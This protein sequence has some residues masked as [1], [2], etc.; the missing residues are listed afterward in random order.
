MRKYVSI[1][2]SRGESDEAPPPAPT[3]KTPAKPAANTNNGGK[4]ASTE[5]V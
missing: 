5:E 1:A 4:S 2:E 3:P